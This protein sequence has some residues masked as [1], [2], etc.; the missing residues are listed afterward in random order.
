MGI[1]IATATTEMVA[2]LLVRN[3][4]FRMWVGNVFALIRDFGHVEPHTGEDV[5][6]MNLTEENVRDE[7]TKQAVPGTAEDIVSILDDKSI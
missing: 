7:E 5:I 4:T 1:F 3:T 2:V 6:N